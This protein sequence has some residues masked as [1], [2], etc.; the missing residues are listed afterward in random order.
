MR[1]RQD[2]NNQRPS[3][4]NSRKDDMAK[5]VA[6]Q[7][8]KILAAVCVRRIYGVVGDSLNRLTDALRRQ[9]KVE[10]GAAVLAGP[11]IFGSTLPSIRVA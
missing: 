7:F 6:D 1:F 4:V 5:T 3:T 9:R 8:A 2:Q 10:C 11:W